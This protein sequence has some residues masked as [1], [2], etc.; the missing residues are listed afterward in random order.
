MTNFE[1]GDIICDARFGHVLKVYRVDGDWT[2]A[3]YECNP[4]VWHRFKVEN[5]RLLSKTKGVN[6]SAWNSGAFSESIKRQLEWAKNV[7]GLPR[8]HYLRRSATKKSKVPKAQ[9]TPESLDNM[10]LEQL[11]ELQ[12]KLGG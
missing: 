12:R 4:E 7:K 8:D 6:M 5:V 1:P 3:F 10:S 9:F 2:D 11:E